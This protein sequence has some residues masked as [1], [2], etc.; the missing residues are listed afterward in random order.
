MLE[1]KED[2]ESYAITIKQKKQSTTPISPPSDDKQRDEIAKATLLSIDSTEA[3][4]NVAK[5]QEK[6]AEEEIKKML[7]VKEDGESYA[8]EF[9]DSMLIDDDDSGTRI[10]PGSHKEHPKP[11]DDD[12]ENDNEKDDA[13][14]PQHHDDHQKD[15][16]PTKGRKGR[17]DKRPRRVQSMQ[18]ILH[19]S[20]QQVLMFLSVNNNN[21]KTKML[22]LN[23]KLLMKM[24]VTT[25]QQHG[26]DYMEQITVMR[27]NDKPD[28]FY[29]AGFKYLNK[30]DIGDLYYLCLDKK[31]NFCK[32]K[33]TNSLITFIRSCVIWERVHDY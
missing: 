28:S 2:G 15:D 17:K 23:H 19:Q 6:L 33:L 9:A 1:V 25:D 8:S 11:V 4:E 27:E 24:R 13:F 10:E 30:N 14:R 31:V 7:E 20:N 12:D 16:A 18:E 22:G 3:Q 21:N 32:N 26:L 5:V 29:E